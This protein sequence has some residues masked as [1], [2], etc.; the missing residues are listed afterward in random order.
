M[1]PS[2]A[3]AAARILLVKTSSMG[4]IVHL[5]PAVTDIAQALP[6]ASIDWLV[7]EGFADLPRLHPALHEAI[8]VAMRRWRKLPWSAATRGEF[9]AFRAAM[10][11]RRYD[12]VIDAQGLVKSAWLASSA[13]G[14]LAGQGFRYAREPLA[15][16]F[17]SRRVAV[18]WTLPAIDTN[19]K[20][21]A[22]VLGYPE[23][24][25]PEPDYGLQ[26]A[27]LTAAWLGAAPYAVLLHGASADTKL[28]PE[29][30][31][32]DLGQSLAQRGLRSVIPWG[33]ADEQ[34]R[35]ERLAQRISHA[36]LAPS[37][38]LGEAAS[39]LA[40][41]KLAIGVDSGL[42]HLAAAL[43]VPVIALFSGSDPSRTG[44]VAMRG[45]F[46]RNLGRHGAPSG[47]Q[48]V[49]AATLEALA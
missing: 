7:E 28:W 11:Q 6:A 9:R 43:G 18:P 29:A 37:M 26:V 38:G 48:E 23:P 41:A 22:A 17:Y 40:G 15:A 1:N 33:N 39:L 16:L 20:L 5:L 47:A 13:Q 4:D 25:N 21:A 19:R 12:I 45:R 8:P 31:W 49:A 24:A 44:V 46:A 42:A 14:P 3:F 34:A 36:V 2:Q 32:I 30:N 35:A 27:H 10:R